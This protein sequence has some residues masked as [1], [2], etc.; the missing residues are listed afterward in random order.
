[1]QWFY[2]ISCFEIMPNGI[3]SDSLQLM[4]TQK[5]LHDSLNT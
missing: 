5:G 3:I 2:V 4:L 1:M